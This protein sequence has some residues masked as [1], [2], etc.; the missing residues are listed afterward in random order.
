MKRLVQRIRSSLE[1]DGAVEWSLIHNL[2]GACLVLSSFSVDVPDQ[3]IK[4]ID[5]MRPA[6]DG[7]P[8]ENGPGTTILP[9]V[10]LSA[11]LDDIEKLA[12]C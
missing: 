3:P 4:E 7:G 12:T 11:V 9:S 8:R 6:D 5:S 1:E 10:R 2:K